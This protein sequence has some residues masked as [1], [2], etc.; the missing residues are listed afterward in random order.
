M[1]RNRG[2]YVSQEKVFIFAS[3]CFPLLLRV[4]VLQMMVFNFCKWWYLWSKKI[5]II[6]LQTLSK[7]TKYDVSYLYCKDES[8]INMNNNLIMYNSNLIERI[9]YITKMFYLFFGL[10]H[11][12][13][14][15]FKGCRCELD[16]SIYNWTGHSIIRHVTL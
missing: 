4:L 9:H 6:K 8:F 16:I 1:L 13:I 2:F 3:D 14:Q 7:E 5:Y 11:Y 10:F 15:S 12:F